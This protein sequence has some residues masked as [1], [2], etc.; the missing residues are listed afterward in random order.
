[1]SLP[2]SDGIDLGDSLWE[3]PRSAVLPLP[4]PLPR[5]DRLMVP[6]DFLPETADP[7]ELGWRRTAWRAGARRLGPG[8]RERRNR[9]WARLARRPLRS[10][11]VIVV[12]SPKGGVGKSTVTAL[13]GGVLAKVRA[14]LVAALDANPD[15]G[16]L[17]TRLSGRPSPHGAQDLQ[18]AAGAIDRYSDLVPYLTT[19]GSGL[20]AVRGEPDRDTR[21]GPDGYL[22]LLGLLSRFYS[23]V[24][25][26]LGTGIRDPAF[27]AV[28]EAADAVVAVAGP[29]FDAIEVLAEGLDWLSRRHSGLLRSAT[30]VINGAGRGGLDPDKASR[31]LSDWAAHVIRLPA[32]RH[33]AEGGAIE[34]DRL[35]VRTQD[36]ALEL[37]ATVVDGLPDPGD[38]GGK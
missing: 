4:L 19:S 8:V 3:H 6:G 36:R 22:D 13:L 27:Q 12:V 31:A 37:A 28:L 21:L 15:S 32:D 10:P 34:W 23:L 35:G 5:R 20:C 14:S 24:V 1:V 2:D 9:E 30:A 18:H 38:G 11:G 25:V 33:L 29:G 7:P 16:N 26:D 17:V